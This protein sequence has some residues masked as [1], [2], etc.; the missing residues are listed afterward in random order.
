MGKRDGALHKECRPCSADFSLRLLRFQ[1]LHHGRRNDHCQMSGQFHQKSRIFVIIPQ[2]HNTIPY[3][4]MSN[5]TRLFNLLDD[6][7]GAKQTQYKSKEQNLLL[8]FE[9]IAKEMIYGGYIR[10]RDDYAIFISKVE[11]YYHEEDATPG[12]GIIDGIVYH[13]DGRFI[14]R[15]VPYFPIMT[16]HSHWSGFDIAFEKESGHYRASALIRQYAVLDLKKRMFI[17]LKTS[18]DIAESLDNAKELWNEYIKTHEEEEIQYSWDKALRAVK[19]H[20]GGYISWKDKG[21][22]DKLQGCYRM[23]SENLFTGSDH[24]RD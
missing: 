6:F 19:R 12:E 4:E 2:N 16:L 23:E 3:K 18:G 13:R 15:D 17:E 5:N 21:E 9:Q 14:N 10:V 22:T 8:Y 11:F 1:H 7:N 24:L 20:Y